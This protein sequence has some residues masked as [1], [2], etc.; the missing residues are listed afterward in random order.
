MT[1]WSAGE[2]R[3]R[4]MDEVFRLYDADSRASVQN[5]LREAIRAPGGYPGTT[6]PVISFAEKKG[7]P[8]KAVPVI[9]F[10]DGKRVLITDTPPTFVPALN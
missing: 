5:P 7:Y 1:G 6:A 2:A 3:G 8:V 10:A 9:G 4:R